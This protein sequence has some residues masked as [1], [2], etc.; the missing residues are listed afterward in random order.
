MTDYTDL[1]FDKTFEKQEVKDG[2]N[3]SGE[4]ITVPDNSITSE[5]IR[6]EA[7]TNDKIKDVSW[8]KIIGGTSTLGGNSNEKGEIE[9]LNSG[10]VKVVGIGKDGLTL[11]SGCIKSFSG[12]PNTLINS[13]SPVTVFSTSLQSMEKSLL[14]A[15]AHVSI[16]AGTWTAT[17]YCMLYAY[18]SVNSYPWTPPDANSIYLAVG[19]TGSANTFKD[20][21]VTLTAVLPAMSGG[22]YY[23]GTYYTGITLTTYRGS[24]TGSPTGYLVSY[25]ID[26]VSLGTPFL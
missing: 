13:D 2:V 7:V 26:V 3:G 22:S 14:I 6:G 21:R 25:D 1:G 12:T 20:G 19:N 17:D 10:G 23:N 18:F 11:S 8:S 9:A 5:K 16:K 15:T 24:T 4:I